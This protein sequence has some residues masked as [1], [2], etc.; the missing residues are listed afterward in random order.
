[1]EQYKCTTVVVYYVS[2]NTISSPMGT[3]D[4]LDDMYNI[5]EQRFNVKNEADMLN[6]RGETMPEKWAGVTPLNTIDPVILNPHTHHPYFKPEKRL[7]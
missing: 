2:G 3:I 1:M 5:I 4:F 6:P 7:C